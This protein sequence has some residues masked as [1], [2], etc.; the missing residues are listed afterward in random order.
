MMRPSCSASTTA[1]AAKACEKRLRLGAVEARGE[2]RA[3]AQQMR[4]RR[5]LRVVEHAQH[6]PCTPASWKASRIQTVLPRPP[7]PGLSATS[8]NS[9]AGAPDRRPTA[10]ARR[11]AS[12]AAAAVR[13]PAPARGPDEA[14]R[15]PRPPPARARASVRVVTTTDSP[16]FGV[17]PSEKPEEIGDVQHLVVE[18]AAAE[19]DRVR[20]G[21][22]IGVLA[23]GGRDHRQLHEAA[24]A[25][26]SR[27]AWRASPP[28]PR[29]RAP[30][31]PHAG[32]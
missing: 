17:S 7:P 14:R 11:T 27:P 5:Q 31:C 20:I 24:L 28:P 12:S 2:A 16:F 15:S 1:S 25:A 32:W 30:A 4:L 23:G 19:G 29:R 10:C 13:H 26:A 8:A 18:E 6:A 22:G 21:A 9:S 3:H